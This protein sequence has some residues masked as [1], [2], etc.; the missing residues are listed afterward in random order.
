MVRSFANWQIRGPAPVPIGRLTEEDSDNAARC[1]AR[2]RNS[3]PA[4]KYLDRG[5]PVFV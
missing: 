2:V 5:R 4:A 1:S 3:G